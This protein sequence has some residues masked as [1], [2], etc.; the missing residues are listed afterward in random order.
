MSCDSEE[1]DEDMGRNLRKS[2]HTE[3]G[4]WRARHTER[5]EAASAPEPDS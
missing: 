2:T 5:G 4:S 1:E 3:E